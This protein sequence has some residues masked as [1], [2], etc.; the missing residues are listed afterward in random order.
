MLRLDRERRERV[1]MERVAFGEL[2]LE[3]EIGWRTT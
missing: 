1:V 3:R 2:D